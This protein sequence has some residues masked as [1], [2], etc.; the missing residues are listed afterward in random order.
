LIDHPDKGDRPYQGAGVEILGSGPRSLS[1]VQIRAFF[2]YFLPGLGRLIA[3]LINSG[4]I[5]Q[6]T[7][8]IKINV[9]IRYHDKH[10]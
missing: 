3:Y 5:F 9:I 10:D 8:F 1:F 7:S 2:I 6:L 4:Q